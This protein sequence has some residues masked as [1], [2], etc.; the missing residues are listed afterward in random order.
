MEC[1]DHEQFSLRRLLESRVTFFDYPVAEAAW[2]HQK[3]P[4]MTGTCSDCPVNA[5]P[6]TGEVRTGWLTPRCAD[7]STD[8][9]IAPLSRLKE[10]GLRELCRQICRLAD[11][12]RLR[13]G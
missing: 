4:E 6:C 9:L 8:T 10:S 1:E 13:L 5:G 7:S 2:L 12:V 11:A 3:S